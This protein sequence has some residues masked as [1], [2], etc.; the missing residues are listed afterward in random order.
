MAWDPASGEILSQFYGH[1]FP[2]IGL[3]PPQEGRFASWSRRGE[4]RVWN[5]A[6]ID[7]PTRLPGH[8]RY[9]TTLVGFLYG[10]PP[11][12]NPRRWLGVKRISAMVRFRVF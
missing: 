3:T 6:T 10:P 5:V 12:H 9:V 2:V 8:S 4:I 11:R 1:Q 7:D